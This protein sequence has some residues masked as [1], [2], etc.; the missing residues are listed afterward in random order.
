MG[1]YK[2]LK[3]KDD[4]IGTHPAKLIICEKTNGDRYEK[5]FFANNKDLVRKFAEFGT[6]DWIDIIF[7]SSKFKNIKDVKAGSPPEAGAFKS[8]GNTGYKSGNNSVRRSDGTSRGDDTN[9]SAAIYLAERVVAMSNTEANLR[10]IGEEGVLDKM[11]K[12]AEH[13]YKFITEGEVGDFDSGD[14]SDPLD[15]PDID[16]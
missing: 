1:L 2:F 4:V 14:S 3:I 5:K 16:D 6:G 10:K 11:M 12:T 7:D 15:P 13:V 8:G 9:R